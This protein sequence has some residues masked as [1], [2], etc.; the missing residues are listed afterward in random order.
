MRSSLR[1]TCLALLVGVALVG[2]AVRTG[3]TAG[4]TAP[5]APGLEALLDCDSALVTL[6]VLTSSGARTLPNGTVSRWGSSQVLASG[7]ND[8]AWVR[9]F[10]AALSAEGGGGP[11]KRAPDPTLDR[12]DGRDPWTVHVNAYAHGK[13][14]SFWVVNLIDGWAG[15]GLDPTL[16]SDLVASPDSL[17]AVLAAGMQ[18]AHDAARRLRQVREPD[19][20]I[21]PLP[22]R[23]SR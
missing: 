8:A 13:V 4:D 2:G 15:E 12:A 21:L 5:V 7:S 10:A 19:A 18:P 22:E 3:H 17:R 23:R 20:A 16:V 11:L 6:H 14:K 1:A 9:R